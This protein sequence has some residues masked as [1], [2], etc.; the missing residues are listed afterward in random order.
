MD[1]NEYGILQT[2][3][4]HRGAKLQEGEELEKNRMQTNKQTK[5]NRWRNDSNY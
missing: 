5:P 1:T 2:S 3:Q 4:I